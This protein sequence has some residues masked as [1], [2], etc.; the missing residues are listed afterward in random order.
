MPLRAAALQ[1]PLAHPAVRAV[2]VGC[3]GR[4]QL[5]E[6]LA[7]LRTPVPQALKQQLGSAST[8]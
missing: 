1:F 3:R 7:L 5:Q 6:N 2:A 4:H 8:G